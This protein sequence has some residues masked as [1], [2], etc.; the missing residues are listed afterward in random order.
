M[1]PE[2]IL[3]RTSFSLSLSLHI[4]VSR[5][6][7]RSPRHEA[8]T[9]IQPLVPGSTV[10][11]LSTAKY[12]P[13]YLPYLRKSMHFWEHTDREHIYWR[14]LSSHTQTAASMTGC[15]EGTQGEVARLLVL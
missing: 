9:P 4:Q 14:Y 11:P 3:P 2:L 1:V 8:Q 12:F 7:F 5:V 15:E 13:R 10:V 6:R